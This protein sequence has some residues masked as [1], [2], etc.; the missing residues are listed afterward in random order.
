MKK[1]ILTVIAAA[2]S[3]CIGYPQNCLPEGITFTTQAQINNFQTNYPG[4]T[5]IEGNVQISGLFNI[6]NLNG[7]NVLTTIG[8]SLVI[9]QSFALTNLTGLDNLTSIG[10]GFWIE[11]NYTLA[12]L[13]GLEN[14]T[15]IGGNLF[16]F[17]NGLLT[18]INGL[19]NVQAS[20]IATYRTG[21]MLLSEY[22][23]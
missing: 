7:L 13:T 3:Y 10:G 6:T 16:I 21:S 17:D 1:I 18:D 5:E 8:G 12:S 23:P 22:L 20:T 15:S 11:N 4:C 9:Q 2:I 14:L 19:D